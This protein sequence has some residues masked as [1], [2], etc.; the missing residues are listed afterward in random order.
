M[1]LCIRRRPLQVQVQPDLRRVHDVRGC[2]VVDYYPNEPSSIRRCRAARRSQARRRLCLA[3]ASRAHQRRDTTS[4]QVN[5]LH[6]RQSSQRAGRRYLSNNVERIAL[7]LQ[8]RRASG[9]QRGIVQRDAASTRREPC[10]GVQRGTRG[11]GLACGDG[12]GGV[13]VIGSL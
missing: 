8:S 4:E 13:V 2:A 3:A 6:V 12:G 5:V 9:K 11:R 10:A 1:G 7:L